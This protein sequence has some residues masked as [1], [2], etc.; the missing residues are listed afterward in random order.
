MEP[1]PI[2]T[3]L[4]RLGGVRKSGKGYTA[5]CPAHED[6]NASLSITETDGCKVLIH[7]FA[8]CSA[9]MIMDSIDLQLSDLFPRVEHTALNKSSDGRFSAR[10]AAVM[11]SIQIFIS[12]GEVLIAGGRKLIS[13]HDFGFDDLVRM[14]KAVQ[15]IGDGVRV[16]HDYR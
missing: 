2:Q 6:S 12:E 8:G 5:K 11:A 1:S 10:Q 16:L 15:I 14:S 4:P 9:V 13:G 7:C 3:I